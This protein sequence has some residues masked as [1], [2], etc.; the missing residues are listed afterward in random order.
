M[1]G[2]KATAGSG[3]GASVGIAGTCKPEPEAAGASS[4]WLHTIQS[5]TSR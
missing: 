3:T 5:R 2:Y 4:L 1:D